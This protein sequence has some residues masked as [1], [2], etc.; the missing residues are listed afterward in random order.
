MNDMLFSNGDGEDSVML[1]DSNS[2]NEQRF[3]SNDSCEAAPVS[4]VVRSLGGFPAVEQQDRGPNSTHPSLVSTVMGPQLPRL[5]LP[6][7]ESW[8]EMNKYKQSDL[9]N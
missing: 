9:T 5:T 1:N 4:S 8:S 2:Q 3:T 6:W 7:S